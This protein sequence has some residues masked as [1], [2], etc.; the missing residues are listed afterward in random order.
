MEQ[1]Q[2]GHTFGRT[3]YLNTQMTPGIPVMYTS[4]KNHWKTGMNI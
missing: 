4:A 3:V 1:Q 2:A